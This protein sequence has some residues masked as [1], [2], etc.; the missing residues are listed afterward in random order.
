MIRLLEEASLSADGVAEFLPTFRV[1][2]DGR[3]LVGTVGIEHY[4]ADGLLRSLAV[5][6]SA[7]SRGVGRA[8][9]VQAMRDARQLGIRRLVLLT[10][11]AADYFERQ[12][13]RR[14]ERASVTGEVTTSSQFRGAC[15]ASAVCMELTL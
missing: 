5:A 4:G 12:G 14:I 2:F 6:R 3:E 9:M 15:P 1:M 10:T 8:L 13:W 7:R 11:T